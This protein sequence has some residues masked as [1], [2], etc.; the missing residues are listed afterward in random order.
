MSIRAEPDERS[1]K[2]LGARPAR[3]QRQQK[4]RSS[5]RSFE[6]KK[7]A[8]FRTCKISMVEC[9]GFEPVTSWLPAMRSTS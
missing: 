5:E 2:R 8:R 3:A 9:T 4:G 1:V 7:Q 6:N